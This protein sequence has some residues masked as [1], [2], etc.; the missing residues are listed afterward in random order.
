[1]PN[2]MPEGLQIIRYEHGG[3]RLI[4]RKTACAISDGLI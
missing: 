3:A 1:M 4:S 2:P